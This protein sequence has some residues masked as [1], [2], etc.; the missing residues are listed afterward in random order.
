[1]PITNSQQRWPWWL[2]VIATSGWLLWMTLNPGGRLPIRELNLIPF[3]EQEWALTCLFNSNCAYHRNAFWFLFI[4]LLGNIV[5]FVPLGFGLVGALGWNRLRVAVGGA[6]L[7]GF[8]FSLMIELLQLAL[9]GRTTDID[10]LIFNTLGAAI[11]AAGYALLWFT[12]MK[13]NQ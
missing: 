11:G 1:M 3:V 7:G 8:A 2:L 5:V 12:L 4:N 10:D 6:V 13:N 9:P